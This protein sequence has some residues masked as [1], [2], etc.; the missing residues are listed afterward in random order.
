[1]EKIGAANPKKS[2]NLQISKSPNSCP[3]SHRHR[4]RPGHRV[5]GGGREGRAN[6]SPRA[7]R[8]GR[9]PAGRFSGRY[10]AS[11]A[12][13]RRC[14]V[15]IM[16][17]ADQFKTIASAPRSF[18]RTLQ[19]PTD[20][21]S[22][23]AYISAVLADKPMGYWPLNEPAGAGG[24]SIAPAMASTATRRIRSWRDSPVLWPVVRMLFGSTAM[25]ISTSAS[26]M[27]LR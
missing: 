23:A 11:S 12:R 17:K 8:P 10:M 24:F 16:A 19:P 13:N 4:H 14:A 1:M 26:A 9:G 7:P 22:E 6:G 25:V 27:S 3:H 15:E 21:P 5:R 2:P 20:T 18:I